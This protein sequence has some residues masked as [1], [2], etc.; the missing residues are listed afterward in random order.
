MFW[1]WMRCSGRAQIS[2]NR[3][4][5]CDVQ[6][7]MKRRQIR[8]GVAFLSVAVCLTLEAQTASTTDLTG[9]WQG[10]LEVGNGQRIVLKV[11]KDAAPGGKPEWHGVEYSIDDKDR[12]YEGRN[13]TGM[14]LEDGAV[15][16]AIAPIRVT[17]QGRLSADGASIGGQWT[18]AGETHALKL[19]RADGDAAWPIPQEQK[20]MARDADPDWD[21]VT[22][23]PGD[24]N[25]TNSG[26]NV[27]GR[28]VVVTRKSVETML[29][30]GYGVHKTQIANAPS[31]VRSELW[32]VKGYADVP[33][34]PSVPQFQSLIRKLLVER[35]GLITHTEQRELAV[36][37]L[38][39]AKGGPKIVKSA[40]D[41]NGLPDENDRENSGQRTMQVENMTMR[42]FCLLLTYFMD[43]PVVDQTRLEGRYDFRLE[44]TFDESRT[45]TD[46]NAPP[47]VFTAIQEQLGLKLEAVRTP[48]PVMVLDAVHR[49][50]SN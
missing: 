46:V 43:R 35:F 23:R 1:W 31:W 47:S 26:I 49:P 45:S 4:A 29:L 36:Y 48:A 8:A 34:Q 18:Q 33:G 16:F 39:V 28:N 9:D 10:T 37:A 50:D 25:G 27:Q 11:T 2:R 21:V 19:V 41:P 40:G 7:S 22:V 24:P 20:A 15:S 32:S 13:T 42:E 5:I 44:W 30:F 38:T 14:S 6:R 3:A 12:G 17:Y